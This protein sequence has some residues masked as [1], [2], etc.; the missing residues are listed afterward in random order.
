MERPVPQSDVPGEHASP[1]QPFPVKPPPYATHGI[2]DDGIGDIDP[3]STAEL[4]RR[5][6]L[7][8][9]GMYT[10][11]SLAGSVIAPGWHGGSTWCGGAFDPA[12]GLLYF[13]SN[14]APVVFRVGKT[15]PGPL[16]YAPGGPRLPARPERLPGGEAAL[17]DAERGRPHQGGVRLEG[18]ARRIPEMSARGVPQT[19]TENFG[20]AIVTAGGLV[21]VAATTDEMFHA[22]DKT[23]G[24]PLW[25][26]KLPAGGY[27]TPATYM[28]GGRQFV[29]IAAG[30]GG[31]LG[32]KSGDTFVA[33]A[34]PTADAPAACST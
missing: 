31:K 14:N 13:N 28:A 29:V 22:F 19:G 27:A 12:T 16:D 7:R 21:F 23:S 11:P 6:G 24:K 18:G 5:T 32:T 17:G 4:A 10:P 1:T 20:G 9:D 30:G 26:A 2:D 25:Q 15:G 34:L 8:R 3:G 33:F